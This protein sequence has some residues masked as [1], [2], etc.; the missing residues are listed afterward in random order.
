MIKTKNPVVHL[1]A[2]SLLVTRVQKLLVHLKAIRLLVTR[3]QNLVVHRRRIIN[4][5]TIARK[6]IIVT[7]KQAVISLKNHVVVKKQIMSQKVMI[8]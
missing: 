3:V 8:L 2:V 5:I 6:I 4:L 1:K 7:K